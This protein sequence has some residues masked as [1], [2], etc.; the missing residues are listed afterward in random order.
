MNYSALQQREIFHLLFLEQLLLCSDP[1]LYVLKGGVNLR[2]F[3][4]SARYSEDMDIDV[5]AGA[6]G[7]LKKN[8]FKILNSPSLLRALQTFGI[9][10]VLINDPLQ[11]KQTETT[12]R[13]RVQLIS[14]AGDKLPTKIEFSRR[15]P[16][17][18]PN[19]SVELVEP[20]LCRRYQR[21][22]FHVQHY[23]GADAVVQKIEALAGRTETQARDLFDLHILYRAGFANRAEIQKRC[24]AALRKRA[25]ERMETLTYDHYAG[26][27]IE[28]LEPQSR[29]QDGTKQV[30]QKMKEQIGELISDE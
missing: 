21:T 19:P 25:S 30:W 9:E 7:T 17:S 16:R 13:F 20:E 28:F 26:Q 8:G 5:L 3:F 14:G 23:G 24:G 10:R 12:Q 4:R 11:S 15:P 18:K 6:V 22:S 2:F 29:N 1:R 27:V